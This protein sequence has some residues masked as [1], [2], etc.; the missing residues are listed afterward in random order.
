MGNMKL[1]F[2]AVCWDLQIDVIGVCFDKW[3]SFHV[4]FFL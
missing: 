3:H 4:H 2:Y 1:S